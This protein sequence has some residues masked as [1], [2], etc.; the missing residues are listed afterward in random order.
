[1][2]LPDSREETATPASPVSSNTINAIQ[3]CIISGKHGEIEIA[4]GGYGWTPTPGSVAVTSISFGLWSNS[5]AAAWTYELKLPVGTLLTE[6]ELAYDRA[7]AGT[8]NLTVFRKNIL[9][10]AA[11]DSRVVLADATGAAYETAVVD[12]L[13]IDGLGGSPDPQLIVA[14]YSYWLHVQ[15]DQAGD[16]GGG[17]IK[18]RKP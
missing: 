5:A 2:A 18:I 6:V 1:M 12:D 15:H 3:D 13:N 17:V 16:F 11:Y 8:V 7:G 4:V 10:G 14:G 9:T